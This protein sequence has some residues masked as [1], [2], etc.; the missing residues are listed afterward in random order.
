MDKEVV[1]TTFAFLT[2][3]APTFGVII[4]GLIVD[5]LGGYTS[6]GAFDF[7]LI[8]SFFSAISGLPIPYLNNFHAVV[9]LL[10]LLLFFGGSMMPAVTGIMISSVPRNM[11][12]VANSIAQL[13]SNTFG[14]FPS[15][16]LY[17]LVVRLSGGGT[18]RSG[19]IMLMISG[20]F[21]IVTSC[22]ARRSKKRNILTI[23]D[24]NALGLLNS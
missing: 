13:C 6:K 17:G 21:G 5:R 4:G 18:S 16:F 3:T 11:R 14:Y 8:C 1:F 15:P 24:I 7:V 23:G 10:W 19:L 9:G 22:L 2:L 20:V 12:A